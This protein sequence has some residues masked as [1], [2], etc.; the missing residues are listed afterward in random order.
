MKKIIGKIYYENWF[1]KLILFADYTTI[2]LFG[3]ILTKKLEA[4]SL[5][6]QRYPK[7]YLVA[8]EKRHELIHCKQYKDCMIL[9]SIIS[10]LL[11]V[12]LKFSFLLLLICFLLI[13]A[14]Y[15]IIYLSEH[16]ISFVYH[17]SDGY[18]K[19]DNTKAYYASAM[20]A[21]AYGN[22]GDQEYVDNMKF[23][24]WFKYYGVI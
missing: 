17:L 2:M 5:T 13:T 11:L 1:A 7:K 14:L 6:D 8:K 15:Y 19:D 16:L 24:S 21:E 22:E 9:G 12:F 20:E 10:I 3:M 23:C 4:K 18:D